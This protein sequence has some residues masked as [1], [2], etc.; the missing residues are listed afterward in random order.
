MCQQTYNMDITTAL[1]R[2]CHADTPQYTFPHGTR[3]GMH[4]IDWLPVQSIRRDIASDTG[5][6]P[7]GCRML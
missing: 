2:M 5:T 1:P 4:G 3:C 6:T 7:V